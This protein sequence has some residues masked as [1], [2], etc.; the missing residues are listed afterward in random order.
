M[1][2]AKY[3]LLLL[4]LVFSAQSYA[5]LP[6]LQQI[7]AFKVI[8]LEGEDIPWVLGWKLL[9][10]RIVAPLA[11][12]RFGGDVLSVVADRGD[13]H[14]GRGRRPRMEHSDCAGERGDSCR[15]SLVHRPEELSPF[16][17]VSLRYSMSFKGVSCSKHQTQSLS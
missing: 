9:S 11:G 10:L 16:A 2:L 13:G 5:I 14:A 8:S 6:P 4:T 15:T 1:N 17:M 7:D 3:T 12:R